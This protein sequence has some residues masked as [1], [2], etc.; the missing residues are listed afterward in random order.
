[1]STEEIIAPSCQGCSKSI[2]EGAV[3]AFGEA[4]FHVN[5]YISVHHVSKKKKTAINLFKNSFVC[6][7]CK[8][9]VN[10]QTNLLLLDDGR[11]VCDNC[12]YNCVLCHQ[13][14]RDEAIMTGN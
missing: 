7:K 4:L 6:A 9:R 3:V 2:E 10:N 11:P 13:V 1:M 8:E 14:I 12:S 5:W